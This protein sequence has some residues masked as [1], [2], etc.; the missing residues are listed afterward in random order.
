MRVS[1][2]GM[3]ALLAGLLALPLL[4]STNRHAD[5][6][7]RLASAQS[8]LSQTLDQA[9]R[10]MDLRGRQQTIAEQKRPD[11][12]VIARV[13]TVLAEAGIPSDRF[14]GLSPESDAALP[15]ADPTAAHIHRRQSVR[16]T[17]N[18]L[19]VSQI[20]EFLARWSVSQPLWVPARIEL[21]HSRNEKTPEQYTLNVLLSATYL[22][23]QESS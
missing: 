2:I 10:I 5:A 7:T 3:L 19:T 13:N 17:L 22:A 21:T 11:Q 9:R 4:I 6:Q 16:I 15:S 12:D 23:Q 1:W 14:G 20:G 18:D 8:S